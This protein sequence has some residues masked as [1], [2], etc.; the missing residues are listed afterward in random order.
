[1]R[2]LI[3]S[4]LILVLFI[5]TWAIFV[6]YIDDSIAEMIGAIDTEIY[7]AIDAEDWDAAESQFDIFAEKWHSHKTV[8]HI[9]SNHCNVRN[10]DLSIIRTQEYIKNQVKADAMAEVATIAEQLRTIL[11]SE[12]FSID[13]IF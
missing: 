11:K 2:P 7:T 13:N 3:I 5:S 4:F 10:T 9:F 1:M 8:Y 6:H 12:S